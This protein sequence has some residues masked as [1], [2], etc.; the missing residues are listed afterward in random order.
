[1]FAFTE[2]AG[3]FDASGR[4]IAGVF[5]RARSPC[6]TRAA[7]AGVVAASDRYVTGVF[8]RA[9]LWT[10]DAGAAAA[11]AVAAA[12]AAA[13]AGVAGADMM[14]VAEAGWAGAEAWLRFDAGRA[15]GY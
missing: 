10:G 2:A 5:A 11:A 7:P 9:G 6:V 4:R 1:M 14:G 15:R 13:A 8:A 3:A 12:A